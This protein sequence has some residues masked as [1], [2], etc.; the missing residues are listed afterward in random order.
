MKRFHFP[1]K[2]VLHQPGSPRPAE[3]IAWGSGD[4]ARC[5]QQGLAWLHG[6]RKLPWGRESCPEP[7]PIP[8]SLSCVSV[9]CRVCVPPSP[10]ALPPP[11]LCPCKAEHWDGQNSLDRTPGTGWGP[12]QHLLRV[13]PGSP[14]CSTFCGL[15]GA[16]AVS[17]QQNKGLVSPWKCCW[18]SSGCASRGNFSFP[19]WVAAGA[20]AAEEQFHPRARRTWHPC[21]CCGR[22]AWLCPPWGRAGASQGQGG[23]SS[24]TGHREQPPGWNWCPSQGRVLVLLPPQQLLLHLRGAFPKAW[25]G[26]PVPSLA[27]AVLLMLP[28]CPSVRP[29]ST[30]SIH[31]PSARL[32]LVSPVAASTPPRARSLAPPSISP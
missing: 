22:T 21:H 10:P 27:G 8:A 9:G 14:A 12:R 1:T 26:I 4:A 24:R 7:E 30:L 20:A 32:E 6:V 17:E 31:T 25:R 16:R 29:L 13:V 28:R 11:S 3:C 5:A 23:G 2:C 19:C 15:R 18:G